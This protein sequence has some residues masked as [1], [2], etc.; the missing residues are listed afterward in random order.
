M[1]PVDTSEIKKI[2]ASLKNKKSSG[3]DNIPIQVVK[4][5][6]DYISDPLMHIINLTL[7]TGIFPDDL[8]KAIIK[9]LYKKGNKTN[10]SNYRPIAL[11]PTFSKIFEKVI[12]IRLTKFLNQNKILNSCQFGFQKGKSTT[13][14][15]FETLK[16]VW[17]SV[18]NKNLC[19]SLLIDMSKAFDCVNFDIILKQLENIGI[20][21]NAL[22]LFYTYL[23]N[24]EQA[25]EIVSYNAQTKTV[26]RVQSSFEKVQLGVPQGSILGP[27]LFLIYLNELPNIVDVPCTLYAD[28]VTL[29][30]SNEN[31]YEN[32]Q[33]HINSVLTNILKWLNSLNLRVNLD[34]T[35]LIQFRNYKTVPESIVASNANTSVDDVSHVSFLGVEIDTHLNWKAHIN[36]LNKKISSR[37][38]A[39]SI[40]SETCS[41]KIVISAYYGTV[42]PLLT[43]GVI[44][45][46]NSVDV[47][48]T[49]ILQKKCLKTVFRMYMDESLREVFREKR[50]LT[51]TGIYILE[52]SQFVK[53]HPEYFTK[54]S[55]KENI[56]S[57]YKYNMVLPR[58]STSIYKKST[59]ISAINV[60][61][62][63]PN[64]IKSLEGNTFKRCLK[65]FL[66]DKVF[67]NLKEFYNYVNLNVY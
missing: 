2:V 26:A 42:Y 33:E 23:Y 44:F 20:R 38:Y 30:F 54:R 13:T 6:V 27:L 50:F 24:R 14:A 57:Q 25:V 22:Q 16:L 28:D 60:F 64:E 31:T 11:L 37:C 18:N 3:H 9:P 39:L 59:F 12:H 15:I 5:S 36:E 34:K 35:K 1:T 46:G 65:N 8:K 17:E 21:G 67:Y 56:R 61:N 55:C 51:L 40:L 62:H 29:L 43:Y 41:E 52:L 45:W 47:D 7:E 4:S 10:L 58:T 32:M 66:I 53:K 48:K 19:A 49:F 63:L